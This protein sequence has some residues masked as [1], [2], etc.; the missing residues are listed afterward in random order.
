[1]GRVAQLKQAAISLEQHNFCES[2]KLGF[3]SKV[4]LTGVD[5]PLVRVVNQNASL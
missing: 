4:P 1:M 2:G 3:S 5:N